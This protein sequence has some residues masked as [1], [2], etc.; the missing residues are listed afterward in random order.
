M[1]YLIQKYA[2]DISAMTK[3]L[4]YGL[5]LL[6]ILFIHLKGRERDR[7]TE[8]GGGDFRRKSTHDFYFSYIARLDDLNLSIPRNQ[9]LVIKGFV[10]ITGATHTSK[11][12]FILKSNFVTVHH[13]KPWQQTNFF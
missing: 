9:S 6:F 1:I 11:D 12:Q 3:V 5:Q 13:S 7:Q 8:K 4:R 2:V 10:N